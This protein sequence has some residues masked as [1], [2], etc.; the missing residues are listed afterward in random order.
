MQWLIWFGARTWVLLKSFLVHGL[1]KS[2]TDVTI[3][4]L[5]KN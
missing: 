4:S 3:L 1:A 2:K 5:P